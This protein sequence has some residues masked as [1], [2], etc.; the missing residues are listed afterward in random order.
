MKTNNEAK[1]NT[2][3]KKAIAWVRCSTDKQH[4]TDEQFKAILAMANRDGFDAEHLKKLGR[5][6]ASAIRHNGKMSD[7]YTADRNELYNLIES[8]EYTTLYAWALD[9]LARD[10]KESMWLKWKCRDNGVTIKTADGVKV[11]TES[12]MSD[13]LI[14]FVKSMIAEDEM[15]K[16]QARFKMGKDI[17]RSIGA[18][19][20]GRVLFG[21]QL[22]A[23]GNKKFFEINPEKAEVVRRVFNQHNNE[24]YSA[25]RIARQLLAEGVVSHSHELSAEAFVVKM[26]RQKRYSEPDMHGNIIVS[27]EQIAAADTLLSQRQKKPRQTYASV[28]YYGQRLLKFNGYCMKVRK[29]D[30]AYVEKGAAMNLDTADSLIVAVVERLRRWYDSNPVDLTAIQAEIDASLQAV[31]NLQ[32]RKEKAAIGYKNSLKLA[33]VGGL[34]PEDI[35][36]IGETH[37]QTV[38]GYDRQI[39]DYTEKAESLKERLAQM[40]HN[41]TVSL[42]SLTAEE[43]KAEVNKILKEITVT[44]VKDGTY[45]LE[46]VTK[47]MLECKIVKKD[48]S[49]ETVTYT[50]PLKTYRLHT[51]AHKAEVWNGTD[52]Q[53]FDFK[54]LLRVK[55]QRAQRQSKRHEAVA[56]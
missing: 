54:C 3:T 28:A 30:C 34:E 42:Y 40:Q 23:K 32:Q 1:T 36:E 48:S 16:K 50:E 31:E 20:G 38:A 35:A 8:G 5:E 52:W 55:P 26:L 15:R 6:G 41:K 13:D 22:V 2:E 56:A 4:T 37:K 27:A 51:K 47:D 39:A 17:N 46:F 14:F 7:E 19:T 53:T 44:K 29:G 12:N 49:H 25:R 10:E 9:R 33:A 11:D 43:V 45:T 18:Y 21:Y 24:G